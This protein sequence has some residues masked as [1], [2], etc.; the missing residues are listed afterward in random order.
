MS[1]KLPV[2]NFVWIEDTFQ[3]NDD[4]IKS[5]NEG[6][7]EGYFLEVDIQYPEKFREL[8]NDLL[9]SPEI[10]K[11]DKVEKLDTNLHDKTEYVI[12][13]RTL[14][15]ALNHGLILKNVNIMIKLNQNAW[16]KPYIDM[17]TK[18]KQKA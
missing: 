15:E 4:F 18:L 11:I 5:H 10:I 8:H 13:I 16:L 14:K 1:Q 9:F 7:D 12:H 3:F 17:D 6:S 2:N